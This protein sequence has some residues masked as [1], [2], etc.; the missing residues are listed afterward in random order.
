[1]STW[2][3]GGGLWLKSELGPRV[4]AAARKSKEY[5]LGGE[6]WQAG[7]IQERPCF[8]GS[9]VERTAKQRNGGR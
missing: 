4:L 6:T 9:G 3:S 7:W 2:H 5:L 1:M 8:Q